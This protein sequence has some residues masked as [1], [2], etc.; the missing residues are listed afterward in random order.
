MSKIIGITVGT[1]MNPQKMSEYI[2][3]GGYEPLI[4]TGKI[5]ATES[6]SA[7][8][9]RASFA[10]MALSHTID[11]IVEAFQ[12]GRDVKIRLMPTAAG[13]DSFGGWNFNYAEM[14]VTLAEIVAA[15]YYSLH[16]Y[17]TGYV[18]GSTYASAPIFI[19]GN[20][21]SSPYV[22]VRVKTETA[23]Y[24]GEVEVN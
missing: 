17:G 8:I 5:P 14:I 16:A 23:T 18:A 2:E 13:M 3:G 15:G 20:I 4:V 11:D 1:T 6:S 9:A 21:T 19:S 10:G 24:A 22:Y 12:A 7:G